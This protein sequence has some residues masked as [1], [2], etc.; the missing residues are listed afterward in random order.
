M[1]YGDERDPHHSECNW[2]AAL[3]D[4]SIVGPRRPWDT[5]IRDDH[6][7]LKCG[8]DPGG[9]FSNGLV[10]H[11]EISA[12]DINWDLRSAVMCSFRQVFSH[13]GGIGLRIDSE[14]NVTTCHFD[15]CRFVM[16]GDGMVLRG[17]YTLVFTT[18]NS[19]SNR[20]WGLDLRTGI[21]SGPARH[22]YNGCWF[23][24]NG[25]DGRGGAI[26]LD[27]QPARGLTKPMD[28]EFNRCVISSPGNS[29]DIHA[30]L[31]RTW[32]S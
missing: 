12:F 8:S 27:M 16:N 23:E 1:L 17:G 20:H 10:E 5:L 22:I 6:V 14:R 7:G 31:R 29:V 13:F 19:E 9:G 21:S 28:V 15:T 26:S 25:W 3:T 2:G 24:E 32:C 30:D 11:V 18:C 4:L